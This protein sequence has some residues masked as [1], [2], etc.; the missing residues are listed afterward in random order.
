[1]K[2]L[3]QSRYSVNGSFIL[4]LS[5]LSDA[6]REMVNERTVQIAGHRRRRLLDVVIITYLVV[7]TRA[8]AAFPKCVGASLPTPLVKNFHITQS[9]HTHPGE[10]H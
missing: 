2:C 8:L 10:V 9:T 4:L 6:G 3:V 5:W 1:M 7:Q